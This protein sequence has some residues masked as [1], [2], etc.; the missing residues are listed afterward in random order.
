M[1]ASCAGTSP[2]NSDPEDHQE[3]VDKSRR[4]RTIVIS[5]DTIF[6]AGI[7][8]AIIRSAPVV[9]PGRINGVGA[10]IY[11]LAGRHLLY[12]TPVNLYG[13]HYVS[14]RFDDGRY[15][16][17]AYIGY[18]ES[19]LEDA[20]TIVRAD[21][22]ARDSINQDQAR[23]FVRIH[24]KPPYRERRWGEMVT[25]DRS[26]AITIREGEIW[27]TG[28]RIGR[29]DTTSFT[30][31]GLSFNQV[32]IYY[33]D[34]AHCATI[35]HETE[36]ADTSAAVFTTRDTKMHHVAGES[37]TPLLQTVIWYLVRQSY[38]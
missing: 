20:R 10:D 5:L 33:T 13:D 37:Q 34:S 4:E 38:L 25:R 9:L 21:L 35:T 32:S 27:Q 30:V 15:V 24:P 26:Q 14:Y 6:N 11:S 2:V 16:D 17:T 19:M 22:L 31:S 36:P 8:Y 23:A 12:T 28:V 3:V 1:A 18:H 7:P 29:Y